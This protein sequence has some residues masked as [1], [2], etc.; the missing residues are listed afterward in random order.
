MTTYSV[1]EEI[2]R[3]IKRRAPM[4]CGGFDSDELTLTGDVMRLHVFACPTLKS[5]EQMNVKVKILELDR[6]FNMDDKTIDEGSDDDVIGEFEGVLHNKNGKFFFSDMKPSKPINWSQTAPY[7]W[8]RVTFAREADKIT[9]KSDNNTDAPT[10]P[11]VVGKNDEPQESP[12]FEIGFL[13]TKEDGTKIGDSRH[14]VSYF[15][16]EYSYKPFFDLFDIHTQLDSVNLLNITNTQIKYA[17]TEPDDSE[18]LIQSAV[19]S[20][21]HVYDSTI[22]SYNKKKLKAIDNALKTIDKLIK[23]SKNPW[24]QH[25]Q[26]VNEYYRK[27]EEYKGQVEQYNRMQNSSFYTQGDCY[28]MENNLIRKTANKL[29][30]LEDQ[31][32]KYLRKDTKPPKAYIDRIDKNIAILTR[33]RNINKILNN[34]AVQIMGLLPGAG[35]V[36]GTLKLIQGKYFDGF[37]DVFGAVV[38]YGSFLKLSRVARAYRKSSKATVEML[39]SYRYRKLVSSITSTDVMNKITETSLKHSGTFLGN[40]F[41]TVGTFKSLKGHVDSIALLH[42]NRDYIIDMTQKAIREIKSGMI[43]NADEYLYFLGQLRNA[44]AISEFFAH[45]RVLHATVKG[46]K[47]AYTVTLE[48]MDDVQKLLGFQDLPGVQEFDSTII[49]NITQLFLLMRSRGIEIDKIIAKETEGFSNTSSIID[50]FNDSLV[51]YDMFGVNRNADIR[52]QNTRAE[53][54]LAIDEICELWATQKRDRDK[55]I[56]ENKEDYIHKYVRELQIQWADNYKSSQTVSLPESLE[57]RIANFV[58]KLKGQIIL[59][60]TLQGTAELLFLESAVKYGIVPGK[61]LIFDFNDEYFRNHGTNL[62]KKYY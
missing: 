26:A 50:H 56:E 17:P 55:W 61:G 2:R 29:N 57:T 13:M 32:H 45:I 31:I 33:S 43:S 4:F 22:D 47:D 12:E 37:L 19:A 52:Y 24:F 53:M 6:Y 39:Y 36:T 48:A 44:T 42:R 30:E 35:V 27:L 3:K 20:T 18:E 9:N 54:L 51:D 5:G 1:P 40:L 28:S 34:P 62:V 10:F 21:T 59:R 23:E 38:T 46:G 25:I 60:E 58:Q 15:Y 41:D 8:F 49:T 11:V 7:P 14:L 16:G